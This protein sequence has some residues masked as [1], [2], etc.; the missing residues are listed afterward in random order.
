MQS[1][2]IP[3]IARLVVEFSR[4]MEVTASVE[5]I[6]VKSVPKKVVLNAMKAFL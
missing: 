5:L 6:T 1:V 3:Q 4:S 2:K